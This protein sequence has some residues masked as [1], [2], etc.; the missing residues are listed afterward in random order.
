MENLTMF[1]IVSVNTIFDH[2]SMFLASFFD[3]GFLS[4][5]GS[6]ALAFAV[7]AV[8]LGVVSESIVANTQRWH[9]RIDDQ[10]AAVNNLVNVIAE[11]QEWPFPPIQYTQLTTGRDR[12]RSLIEKCNSTSASAV[13]RELRNTELKAMVDLCLLHVRLWAYG[14]YELGTLSAAEVHQ[15]GFLLP[16][17]AGGHHSR[18][19]VTDAVAEVKAGVV[20]LDIIRVVIDQ[21]AGENAAQVIHG[22]PHGVKQALIIVLAADGVTEVHR[23][24]TSHLHTDI[25]VPAG[26]RGKLL[27]VKAAF[28]RHVDDTPR[29]GNEPTVTMPLTTEDL[30][31]MTVKS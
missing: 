23:Q 16:G 9:G 13:D 20:A 27:I 22:W 6:P 11:H 15:L 25:Q 5:A 12:L 8:A 19:E 21:S 1:L 10:F 30:A 28:L 24:L 26:S 29:F 3:G 7:G 17:E 18:K 31:A 14:N 2:V 4:A